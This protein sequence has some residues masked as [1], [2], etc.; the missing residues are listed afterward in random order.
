MFSYS[1]QCIILIKLKLKLKK[2][3][4]KCLLV[5]FRKFKQKK[6]PYQIQIDKHKCPAHTR[7]AWIEI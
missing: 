5:P 7:F 1:A 6:F 4:T 3:E 2:I